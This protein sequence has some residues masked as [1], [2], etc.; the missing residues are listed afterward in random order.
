MAQTR[1]V[2]PTLY[3]REYYLTACTG[4]ETFTTSHGKVLEPRLQTVVDNAPSCAGRRVLDIGCGRGELVFYAASTGARHVVGIDYSQDS[5]AIC[6]EARRHQAV[7]VQRKTRFFKAD[8][9]QLPF[10]NDSFDYVFCTEVWEHLYP[11][12]V[13]LLLAEIYRI[14]SPNGILVIHTAPTWIFNDYTYRWWCYPVSSLVLFF[15]ELVTGKKYPN[16]LHPSELRGAYEQSMH[17]NESSHWAVYTSLRQAGFS[18]RIWSTNQ[19]VNKPALSWKDRLFNAL[20]YLSPISSYF[21]WF[22]VW[23]NDVFAVAHKR[24]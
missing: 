24:A 8:A 23:G 6:L 18:A 3:T 11:E 7:T 1:R 4:Y 12:E 22:C 19:T 16:I 5:I 13:A 2:D 14:L 10:P 21:P 20:V 9:T 17:V 15:F